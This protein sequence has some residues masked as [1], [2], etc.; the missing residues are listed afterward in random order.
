MPSTTA[1]SGSSMV[2]AIAFSSGLA[3]QGRRTGLPT[4]RRP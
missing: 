4:A 1:S 3:A 2:M